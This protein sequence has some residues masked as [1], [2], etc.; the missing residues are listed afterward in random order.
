MNHGRCKNCW[1]Y[2][3][4]QGE[5]WRVTGAGLMK[6]AGHGLCYMHKDNDTPYTEKDGDSYCWDFTSRKKE[7]RSGFETLEEW[8]ERQNIK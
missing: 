7:L 5:N 3:E 8:M 1:W 2:K 4:L 6:N